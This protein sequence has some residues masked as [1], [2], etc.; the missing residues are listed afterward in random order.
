VWKARA[1]PLR[2]DLVQAEDRA[3]R[4]LEHGDASGFG[5][6]CCGFGV[7]RWTFA[8]GQGAERL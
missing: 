6:A 8:L 1:R 4:I 5:G 7:R 3:L 2:F